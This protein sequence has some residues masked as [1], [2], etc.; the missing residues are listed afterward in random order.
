PF[1][2]QRHR[3]SQLLGGIARGPPTRRATA[4]SD[5]GR[6]RSSSL[7][8]LTAC[9]MRPVLFRREARIV[10]IITIIIIIG[11]II[12]SRSSRRCCT[13]AAA[14]ARAMSR[15][16]SSPASGGRRVAPTWGCVAV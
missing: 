11:I 5:P 10:T 1:L 7:V 16:A 9:R 6:T 14:A 3:R 2:G 4:S 12:I 15:A 13:T 8:R